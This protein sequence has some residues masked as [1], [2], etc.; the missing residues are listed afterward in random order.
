MSARRHRIQFPQIQGAN[1]PQGE[2]YFFLIEDGG[3]KQRIRFYD[4]DTIYKI[5]GLY[6]CWTWGLGMG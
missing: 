4:Y 3:T 5:P 1:L 2:A 6:K